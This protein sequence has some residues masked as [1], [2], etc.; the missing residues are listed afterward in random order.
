MIRRRTLLLSTPALSL[1]PA[2]ALAQAMEVR[3]GTS[4]A[5]GGFVAYSV[6]LLEALRAVDPVL[7]IRPVQTKGA[8]ENAELL[9]SGDIDIGLVGGEVMYEWIAKHPDQPRLKI[10]S[11]LYSAPG[12][13]AVRP[14][15]R[16][17]KITDLEGRPVVWSP[18]GT[19]SAVQARYVMD[20]LGLDQ[21][22]DFQAIYPERFT[23]GPTLVIERRA[24]ALWG[25]GYRWPG[26]VELAGQPGGVRFIV[27]S[28][29][30]IEQIRT[31]YAFLVKLTV[32]PGLYPGQYDPIVT[33]GAWSYILAR[34][35]LDD[36]V[37]HRLAKSLYKTERS[38]MPS[39]HTV[40]TTARNTLAAIASLD[41]LHPGVLRFYREAKLTQ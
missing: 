37:G 15:T 6:A 10:I 24:S 39:K 20:G 33:V 26:F 25:S 11:V 5:G 22:R 23:D 40:Q 21:D 18:R 2:A 9:Q 32:P 12:M 14:E 4:T 31:K 17:R 29:A 1:A 19:A 16:Y 27:P 41:E 3:L 30:E 36:A 8:T 7:D 28:A 35:D 13:F 34:P 38:S